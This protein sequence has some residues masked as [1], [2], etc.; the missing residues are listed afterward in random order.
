MVYIVFSSIFAD[1]VFEVDDLRS[2]ALTFKPEASDSKVRTKA[3]QIGRIG[4][5]FLGCRVGKTRRGR[6]FP[7]NET[8]GSESDQP[9][10]AAVP[11]SLFVLLTF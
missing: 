6:E 9:V 10:K 4:I 11:H 8:Q 1:F 5:R 3:A 2:L 7:V